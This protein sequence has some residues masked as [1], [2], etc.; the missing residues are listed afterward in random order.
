M[1]L[2]KNGA[3]R[4]IARHQYVRKSG[5]GWFFLCDSCKNA[6]EMANG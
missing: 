2:L 3:K 1:L 5:K 4:E 6:V